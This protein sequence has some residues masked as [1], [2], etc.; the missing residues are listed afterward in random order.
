MD[1]FLN[2]INTQREVLGI[3]NS[4]PRN[5]ALYGLSKGAIERWSSTNNVAGQ[6]PIL[7][8]LYELGAK[9][10]FLANKS[11]QQIS[12]EYLAINKE[13]S[14]LLKKLRLFSTSV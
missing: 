3:V 7:A 14:N 9:L 10:S 13:V 5:E 8:I 4:I 12:N 2:R 6:D 11:Q 1:E